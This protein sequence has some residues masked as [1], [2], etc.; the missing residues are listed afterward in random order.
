MVR[1]A[2]VS[3]DEVQPRGFGRL[4]GRLSEPVFVAQLVATVGFLATILGLDIKSEETV[5]F[6]ASAVAWYGAAAVLVRQAV[7][8]LKT[9]QDRLGFNA[10]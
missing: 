7:F 8:A 3:V 6:V 10:E 2:T 9:L 5:S 4:L 1:T